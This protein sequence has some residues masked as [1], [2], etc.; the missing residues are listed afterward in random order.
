[1]KQKSGRWVYCRYITK[2]GRKI[3]PR[4]KQ[5]FKFWVEDHNQK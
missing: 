4:N 5:V 2:N 3:Y 1:M